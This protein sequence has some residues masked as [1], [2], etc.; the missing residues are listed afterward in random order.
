MGIVAIKSHMNNEAHKKLESEQQRIKNFFSN[1]SED[2]LKPRDKQGDEYAVDSEVSKVSST[3]T[4]STIP[5]SLHN[6]GKLTAEIRWALKHVFCGYSDNSVKGLINSFNIMFPDSKIASKM[7]LGK[8]KLKY[9]VNYGIAPFFAERLKK[10]VDESEWLA[11]S[12]YKS[13]N[14]VIQECE[15]DL[16]LRFWDT[17]NN[18]VQVRYWDSM[19]L[20]HATAADLMKNINLIYP[21]KC[22]CRWMGPA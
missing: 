9:A 12:Y 7:E 16:M 11:V 8:N 21:N 14:K 22:N 20:G 15:M 3:E 2:A 13:L 5:H 1:K 10:Q 17:C 4:Q 19:F 6:D 18:K